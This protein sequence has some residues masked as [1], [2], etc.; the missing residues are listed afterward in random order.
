LVT[1]PR[2]MIIRIR[3][4]ERLFVGLGSRGTEPSWAKSGFFY[5]VLEPGRLANAVAF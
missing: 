2:D 5:A 4:I 3:R 1:A